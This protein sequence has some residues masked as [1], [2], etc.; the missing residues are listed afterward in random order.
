MITGDHAVTAA[1]IA[2]QVGLTGNV[3]TG[4]EIENKEEHEL[5]RPRS[6]NQYFRSCKP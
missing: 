2:A 6:N 1:A 4:E 5:R 3:V